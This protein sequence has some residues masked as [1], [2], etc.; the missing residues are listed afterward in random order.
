MT[1]KASLLS[2]K[3]RSPMS[4]ARGVRGLVAFVTA[5]LLMG[6]SRA[7]SADP[8]TPAL[9]ATADFLAAT[10]L[11]PGG[12][13]HP[14]KL[15]EIK[16]ADPSCTHAHAILGWSDFKKVKDKYGKGEDETDEEFAE[17]VQKP[18]VK[19]GWIVGRLNWGREKG[20]EYLLMVDKYDYDPEDPDQIKKVEFKEYKVKGHSDNAKA[21]V[22]HC[23]GGMCNMI[24]ERFYKLYK[25]IGTPRVYCGKNAIPSVIHSPTKPTIPI[26]TDEDLAEAEDD[27]WDDDS[28]WD[29]GDDDDD[30]DDW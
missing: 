6:S 15:A 26:P 28:D 4:M 18:W 7:V 22:A 24:A 21:Y 27:D 30:D 9:A 12:A 16:K 25:G 2:R 1:T 13:A 17:R 11:Q 23:Y 8:V 20:K 10:Q 5:L 29:F 3:A 14:V 19:I